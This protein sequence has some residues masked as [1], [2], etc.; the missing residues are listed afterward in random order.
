MT[1][2]CRI[3]GCSKTNIAAD[4]LCWAHYQ[5]RKRG[6]GNW[7]DPTIQ[8]SRYPDDMRCSVDGCDRKTHAKEFCE[9]HY[10]RSRHG[11]G[12]NVPIGYRSLRT[13]GIEGCD[14]KHCGKG[15]CR[16]HLQRKY[17]GID[18]GPPIQKRLMIVPDTCTIDECGRKH[19]SS[20]FCHTHYIRSRG[21][22]GIP[23]NAPI[24]ER[25]RKID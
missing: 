14:R 25:G 23:L 22:S 6:V 1:K 21:I 9:L 8:I 3:E 24:Q 18:M 13:C 20:G 12:M 2:E 11:K 17:L 19:H 5:R 16:A 10:R 7:W 15:L 4:N